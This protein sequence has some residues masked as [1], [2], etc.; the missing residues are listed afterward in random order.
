MIQSYRGTARR[1]LLAALIGVS[2]LAARAQEPPRPAP[3]SP[4]P[5]SIDQRRDDAEFHAALGCFHAGNLGRCQEMLRLLLQRRPNHAE[6]IRLLSHVQSLTRQRGPSPGAVGQLMGAVQ[7]VAPAA[8][9]RLPAPAS[10]APGLRFSPPRSQDQTPVTLHLD[11][12]EVRK[13]LELLSR[14]GPLNILV[15]ANVTGRITANLDGLSFDQALNAILKLSNLAA[16]REG[17]LV[18]VFTPE[19]LAAMNKQS[20]QVVTR[21][22]R[23]C[24]LR[25]SD[26]EKICTPLLSPTVGRIAIT[27]ISETGIKSN[28]DVAGGDSLAGGEAIIVQDYECVLETIDHIIAS[29]MCSRCRCSSRR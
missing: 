28:T 12:V 22:Y 21:V 5:P 6:A 23:L 26:L 9:E 18:Y 29:S 14:Q 19:E 13:A 1:L 15:S 16:Q 7:P 10:A 11:D 20:Q 3:P 8:P 17:G 24:Y 4:Q 2:A 27:P 25:G